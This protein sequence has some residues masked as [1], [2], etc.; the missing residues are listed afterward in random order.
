[1][2]VTLLP[3]IK[4]SYLLDIQFHV[5]APWLPG[6][7]VIEE[8]ASAGTVTFYLSIWRITKTRSNANTKDYPLIQSNTI[9]YD[10]SIQT[11][12]TSDDQCQ[13]VNLSATD[14]FTVPA[15]SVVGF[16]S[17]IGAQLLH[18]NTDSSITTYQFSGNQSNISVFS[19][20]D[21]NYNI[22]IRVHLGKYIHKTYLTIE[23]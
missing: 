20:G 17:G 23:I 9:T 22:A 19:S 11:N 14:Q 7:S 8:V 15:G 1:M 21:I 10:A 18:T 4:H 2:M 3:W 16:Y 6:N 5:I 12:G 13:R